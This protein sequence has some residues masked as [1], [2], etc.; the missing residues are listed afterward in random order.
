MREVPELEN[1]KPSHPQRILVVEDSPL[2]RRCCVEILTRSGYQVDAAEDGLCGWAA[3]CA[4][5]YDLLITDN[6]M[7]NM[8]GVELILKLR[9]EHLKLP[10][11]LTSGT[12]PLENLLQ[13]PQLDLAATLEKP[14]S[15]DQLIQTVRIVLKG[16]WSRMP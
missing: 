11:I 4:K 1:R 6:A 10:V 5:P 16:N 8:S 15:A 2:V 13:D 14:V 12:L 3:L 9:S 7:P